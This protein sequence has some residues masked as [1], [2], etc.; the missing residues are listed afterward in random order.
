MNQKTLVEA[1]MEADRFMEKAKKALWELQ[2]MKHVHICG[3][4]K[5]AAAR[6]ASMDLTR[7][8]AELRKP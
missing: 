1:I 7:A 3:T 5:S 4:K 2:K 8:L 6:R